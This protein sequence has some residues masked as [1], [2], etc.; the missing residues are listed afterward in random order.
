MAVYTSITE[1][2]LKLFLDQ[3]CVGD[4]ENFQGILEGIENTNYKI[5]TS[6]DNYI[7]TIFEKR[8]NSKDIPFFVKLQNYLANKNFSC[9]M[10]IVNKKGLI[11]NSING[12][13]CILISFLNGKKIK[14]KSRI[15]CNQVGNILSILHYNTKNY[16]EK[17]P[18]NMGLSQWNDILSKCKSI[19]FTNDNHLFNLI[20]N[21]L[22]FLKTNWPSNLPKGIIHA[23]AFQDNIFFI[24]DKFSGLIDF[25]FAC[26]DFLSYDIALAINAWCFNE[27]S[28]LEIENL[29][30]LIQGYEKKRKITPKEKESLSILLRGAAI[31]ILLTRLH[32]KLFHSESAFVQPKDHTEY[33]KI[34]KFHQ[35]NNI[36]DFLK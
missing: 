27:N 22:I 2:E 20:D 18:N 29:Q 32:D 30:S 16:P 15:H 21:E 8:V 26:H 6:K 11:I 34:L 9:P 33:L 23:D 35:L 3:Y 10:P 19:T 25:Y 14:N 36:G 5:K 7:L 1:K 31:R 28:E 4:L 13:L 17:R 24:K 12:K